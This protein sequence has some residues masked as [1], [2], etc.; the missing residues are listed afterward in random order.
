MQLTLAE[1]HLQELGITEPSEIDLEAIAYDRGVRIHYCQLDGCEARIVGKGNRA[2]I[3]VN[4]ASSDQRQRFSIAHELGHWHHH[5]GQTL[6]CRVDEYRPYQAV[7]AERLADA[8]AADLILPYYLFRPLVREYRQ[9]TLKAVG[10]LAETFRASFTATAIR[11][12]E[13]DHFPAVLVCHSAEGRRWFARAPGVPEHWF[14]KGELA[15]ESSA[16]DILFGRRQADPIPRTIRASAW[17]DGWEAHRYEISEQTTRVASGKTLTL[18][19]LSDPG[20]IQAA[21]STS[22]YRY[23]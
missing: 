8:Y 3:T 15:P 23:R 9:L 16:L 5:R 19:V 11:L 1:Q 13:C 17:F 4:T 10:L 14:P 21:L 12:I 6:T 7:V 20:M 18:L 22:R 2:I